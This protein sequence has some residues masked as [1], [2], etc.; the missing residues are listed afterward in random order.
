MALHASAGNHAQGVAYTARL[1]LNAVIFA[2]NHPITKI[3][4][5]KFSVAIILK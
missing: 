1:D 4:Q 2:S 3:N 5:V